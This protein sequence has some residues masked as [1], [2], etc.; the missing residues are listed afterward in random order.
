MS[1]K[2][3][4]RGSST[5]TK[6]LMLRLLILSLALCL[7]AS[8]QEAKAPAKTTAK[9]KAKGKTG[10]QREV[11]STEQTFANFGQMIR[12]GTPSKKVSI[13]SFEEG[14]ATSLVKA[15]VLTRVSDNELLASGMVIESYADDPKENLTVRLLSAKYDLV[16]KMLTS[17]ERSRV[18]RSDFTI[19]GDS[20]IYDTTN[21]SGKMVGRVIMIINDA[22]ALRTGPAEPAKTPPT[23]ADKGTLPAPAPVNVTTP[24]K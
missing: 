18:E 23:T 4:C 21:G 14:K 10:G 17:T 2:L 9:G 19:E 7:T 12:M 13:P 6:Q 5:F 11:L 24:A 15:D 22:G 3:C 16:Q 1:C 20:M 8:A